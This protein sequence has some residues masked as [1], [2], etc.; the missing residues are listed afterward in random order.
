MNHVFSAMAIRV[1]CLALFL[2]VPSAFA[3]YGETVDQLKERYGQGRVTK[4]GQTTER[5]F[6]EEVWSFKKDPFSIKAYVTKGIC[7]R[8]VYQ[9]A[10]GS[11]IKPE[12]VTMLLDVN[13]GD[14]LWLKSDQPTNYEGGKIAPVQS[15]RRID[16]K[17][18]GMQYKNAIYFY[19]PEYAELAKA[20]AIP[21]PK[22]PD[23]GF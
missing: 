18:Y 12:D 11:P 20:A 14:S 22:P 6:A 21:K 9:T 3:R 10:N 19:S 1:A 8:I 16:Q 5:H 17:A 13:K 2:G 4:T 7:V 23:M 15:W